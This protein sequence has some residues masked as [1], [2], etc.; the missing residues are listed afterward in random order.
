[1]LKAVIDTNIW[2]R[3]L[4]AGR[5]AIPVLEEWRKGRFQV[6]VS[7]ALLEELDRVCK[8]P[9]LRERINQEHVNVLLNQLRWRGMMVEV[10][11]VPPHCRDP[12]DHPVLAAA[13]DGRADVIVSADS[14][15]RGDEQLQSEMA[16]L[17]VRIAGVE[18]FLA[19]LSA[20]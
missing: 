4:L 1:M 16:A 14:D 9:R 12:K 8:R 6:I 17:R 10:T 3:A 11:S 5:T 20:G 7:E 13:I 19:G 15:L 18:S 2:V